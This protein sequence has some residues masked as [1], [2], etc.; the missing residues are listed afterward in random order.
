MPTR[1]LRFLCVLGLLLSTVPSTV[2]AQTTTDSVVNIGDNFFDAADLSVTAGTTVTW[3]NQGRSS[4]GHTVVSRDQLFA[5]DV[6]RNGDTFSFTFDQPGDYRYLC[7]NHR[8][9]EGVI[10]VA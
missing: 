8:D 4:Q 5:S 10:H 1:I 7:V 3:I 9:Q 2:V 6:L